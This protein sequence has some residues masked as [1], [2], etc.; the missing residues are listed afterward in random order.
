MR[1]ARLL[2]IPI[3]MA[4]MAQKPGSDVVTLACFVSDRSG[5]PHTG[6][7]AGDFQ[8][9]DEGRPREVRTLWTGSDLP[10]NLA[11]VADVSDSQGAYIASH[12]EPIVNFLKQV[13][14]PKDRAMVVV[15]GRQA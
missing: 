15:I 4:A 1:I 14:G 11:L 12:R 3:A 6:L 9:R 2:L 7:Q 5:S 13:L 8:V 10:L